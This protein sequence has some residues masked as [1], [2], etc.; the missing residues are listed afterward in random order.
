MNHEGNILPCENITV[1][2]C[3]LTSS[4]CAFKFGDE[5]FADI[6]H[7]LLNNCVIR[8]SN[9]GVGI[10][11]REKGNVSDVIISHVSIECRRK[12]WFWWGDGD[13]ILIMTEETIHKEGKKIT[14]PG[15][16]SHVL[17]KNVIAHAR[18]TSRIY[19]YP[20]KPHTGIT[21]ETVKIMVTDD[22]NA[23]PLTSHGLEC[24]GVRGLKL[25]DVE[26]EWGVPLPPT[27]ESALF[28]EDIRDLE[29]SGF[30]GCQAG[31]DSQIPAVMLNNVQDAFIHDC[32]ALP[33]TGEFLRFSGKET[34]NISLQGNQF[35]NASIPYRCAKEVRKNAVRSEPTRRL[36]P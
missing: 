19:S 11:L 22:P 8:D 15:T 33:G 12:D 1:T 28:L 34:G 18:G 23:L 16:I 29:L 3:T 24:R 6:R 9:R 7:V 21:L 20:G 10:C 17:I 14:P 5:I 35:G 30:R 25:K 2:N 13:P 36:Q 27:G 32:R 31:I 4:S 26:I